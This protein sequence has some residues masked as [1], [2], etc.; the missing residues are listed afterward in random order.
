MGTASTRQ[1][2]LDLERIGHGVGASY[3]EMSGGA[4]P[5]SSADGGSNVRLT[6][7]DLKARLREIETISDGEWL[8]SLD[9]RKVAELEFHD[10]YRDLDRIEKLD[11]DTYERFYGNK[12][13]YVATRN[14]WGYVNDRIAELSKDRI[15]LDYCCGNG[16]NAQ[17][18]AHAGAKLAIGIDISR[19]SVENATQKAAEAGL[20]ENTWFVQGDAENTKLPDNSIDTILCSGA[21]HHLDLSYA[22]HELRRVLA[23]GGRVI[24]FEALDY[25]PVIKAYRN[26]TPDMR[27]AWESE[28]ILDL[29]DLDFARRFFDVEDTRYWHISAILTP[30]IPWAAALLGRLDDLLTRVPLV[31]LMAWCWSFELVKRED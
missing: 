4:A 31:Q 29:K 22:F 20:A 11:E 6:L 19:V 12:K 14:S 15:F 3:R 28:H 2:H 23:P 18:A 13:Y 17:K 27:T 5:R 25:N 26:R 1:K 30:H 7:D 16:D 10:K 21:L 8:R 9:A 24:V